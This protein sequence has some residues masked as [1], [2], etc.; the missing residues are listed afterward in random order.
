MLGLS[1][2][3]VTVA[4][5]LAVRW[6]ISP[7]DLGPRSS[8]RPAGNAPR[9]AEPRP[10]AIRPQASRGQ[11]SNR[12]PAIDPRV[13][14][15]SLPI[16][17]GPTRRLAAQAIDDTAGSTLN[18]AL[19]GLAR[20][21]LGRPSSGAPLDQQPTERLRLDLMH[22]D[23]LRFLE[24]LLALV[25]S[26][27]VKT[28]TEAVDRFSDHVRQLRYEGGEVAY[29]RRHHYFSRW[30][31]AAE[32]QGY[33][34]NLTPFLPGAQQRRR[35][36]TFLSSHPERHRP[37]RQPANRICITALEKT[38]AVDQ[39]YVPLAGLSA[40][41]PSLRSGDIV[42]FV[43]R[44]PGLDVSDTGMVDVNGRQINAI[45][46]TDAPGGVIRS[47]ELTRLSREIDGVI[48]LAFYRPI[49][50][51]DGQPNR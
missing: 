31:Q 4:G 48:G 41:L 39:A 37:M 14:D 2:L 47:Q 26:R 42:A 35:P 29:C 23:G 25:N 44:R 1:L 40:V 28:R 46:T 11:G 38:L 5:T 45:H 21:S 22:L 30:G 16:Y 27:Q 10:T 24:Q 32:R 12:L 7:V 17:I 8:S 33:L 49:P 43:T 3:L 18:Q 36:L 6:L 51:S 50:N 13:I 15:P 9:A 20:R 34:V 19:I